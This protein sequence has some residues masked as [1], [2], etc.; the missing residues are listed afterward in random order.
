MKVEQKGHTTTIKDTV[1]QTADF[2]MKV[3]HEHN[4]YKNSNLI[5][6]LTHDKNLSLEDVKSFAELIKLHKKQKKSIVLVADSVNFN[7]VPKSILLVPTLL[8]A[9]DIIEMEEIERDLG[10]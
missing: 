4:S 2:L 7:A 3:T 9:H 10:F 1:G 8:E 6:D 5:L